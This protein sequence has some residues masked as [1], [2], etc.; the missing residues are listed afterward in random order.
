MDQWND[1][2]MA[3]TF[4]W[5]RIIAGAVLFFMPHLA[6]KFWTNEDTADATTDLAARGMGVRDV[7]IG[8][9]LVTALE[10]GASVRPWLEAGALVDAGDALGTLVSWRGPG[11]VRGMF[12][13]LT[14]VVSAVL[15]FS[16][17]SRMD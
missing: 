15:G 7:A 10:K 1:E 17:A 6:E 16:L 14:E 12:W 2:D 5:I 11:K 8:V 4:G 9:G 3:R 13:F